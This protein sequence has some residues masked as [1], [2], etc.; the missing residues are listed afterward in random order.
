VSLFKEGASVRKVVLRSRLDNREIVLEEGEDLFHLAEEYQKY[1]K[2]R[3]LAA[4]VNNRIVELFRTPDRSG[5][6]DFIDLTDPDGLRIYQRGLVFLASLAVRKLNPDWRLKVLHSLG[7]G[8][9]CEIY[10]KDRLIV[11]DSQQV[12]SIKEKME[13]LVQKDLPIEKRTFYKDEAREILLREGLEKTVRLFKYRKKR[14]VKLYHCDGFWAYFYGYL[15]PSTGRINVFDVQ[16]YNQGIVLVHPDPKTGDLPTIHMPKLSRVFLEYARW[17]SVLEIEYVSDLND[18]I[19]HSERKVAELMLLSEALHEK[20]ISD[21]ADEIT[22][23]RRRRLVLIAGP[24]SSGKTTFAKRLSLQLRVNGLKPVAISLD[25]YFV[26]REKTPRDENG[27]YDFDSIEA[28]DVDLFNRHLQDLLAGKEVVLPKFNF[29]TGKRMRGPVLKL[30]KDNIIIV[31]G[32]HGL[33]ERL[34]ASIPKEQKFKIYVSALTQLNIDDHNRVTTTDTRLLRRIV[35]DYKF[36]G[37]TA[38]DTLKMWPNVRKGEERNIF[39]YQEEADAMFNSA[40]VYEIPVLRIFAEPLLVQVP[41]DTPEYS[42]ALRLLKLL[43]FFLPITNIEDIPDKSI[44]REFI[45][46][47]IFKY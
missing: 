43:D 39:P 2:Y 30:E 6:L 42:E 21:I 16:A 27:N 40:L 28:L 4:K 38:Y 44:L 15:P 9:Y 23:D 10:E 37:H 47:S 18:L 33:N 36:R 22:K 13:E 32:I 45:G 20:K 19:A 5:E 7:K 12:I 26:D 34:T 8:I 14:T 11:P 24:S 35:R 17:L 31:E 41:E 29:K 3:I 25:D 46:R 1:F